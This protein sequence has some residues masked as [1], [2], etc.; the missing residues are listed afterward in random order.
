M[1]G[2]SEAREEDAH[3]RVLRL[4]EAHPDFSQRQIAEA[5]GLSLGGANYCLKALI[6]KGLVKV[7]NFRASPQKMR[8]AYILT[9][10]GM[11]EKANLTHRFLRRKMQEFD[12]LK[13]EI[14]ALR[15]EMSTL[16]GMDTYVAKAGAVRPVDV[17]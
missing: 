3:F 10:S 12:E 15:S 9:P 14:E 6:E 16:S 11:V 2:R 1:T 7:S 17:A 8:Y 4:L 13:A 5:A